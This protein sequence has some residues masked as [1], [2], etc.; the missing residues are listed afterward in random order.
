MAERPSEIDQGYVAPTSTELVSTQQSKQTSSKQSST[1]AQQTSSQQTSTP[2]QQSS[3]QQTSSQQ[4]SSQQT[5]STFTLPTNI[6]SNYRIEFFPNDKK[7]YFDP[8][9]TYGFHYVFTSIVIILFLAVCGLNIFVYLAKGTQTV[10]DFINGLLDFIH[11]DYGYPAYNIASVIFSGLVFG[12]QSAVGAD[13][14]TQLAAAAVGTASGLGKG[15]SDELAK[16]KQPTSTAQQ[17]TP[18]TKQQPTPTTQQPT[19]TTPPTNKLPPQSQS[20]KPTQPPLNPSVIEE[21][22]QEEYLKQVQPPDDDFGPSSSDNVIQ[23]RNK[24]GWCFIGEDR[25]YRSCLLVEPN[26]GCMSGEVYPSETNCLHP[27]LRT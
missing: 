27:E 25:G 11:Q 26:T 1:P 12:F 9:E 3:S 5:S 7:F 15:N 14:A 6:P 10:S 19:P 22:K 16:E 2:S 8:P 24:G 21:Q 17:P 23:N 4:T 13:A 18:T 20:L